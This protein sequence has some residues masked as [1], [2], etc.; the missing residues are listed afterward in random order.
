MTFTVDPPADGHVN[1]ARD[2]ELL[3]LAEGGQA[4]ARVYTWSEI[5]V[6]LGRF[7]T[8]EEALLQDVPSIVRPTG[9]RAVL[10]GHDM[11]VGI[12]I[13]HNLRGGAS[14]SVR[15]VYRTLVRPLALALRQ[16][17][18][19]AHLAEETKH[20]NKG[21]V[22][23]DCFAFSSPNDVVDDV[24][25]SKVCGCAL[26]VT[27]R[28]ALLQASI[29]YRESLLPIQ[30][31]IQGAVPIDLTPWRHDLLAESLRFALTL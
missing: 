20:A 9:G 28:A 5:W 1:M 4:G 26:R 11:T 10:H 30:E 2:V 14:R 31:V 17:G 16:C 8:A 25:G 12:A 27:D 18:L 6:T 19:T 22:S 23:A 21:L 13:P 24:T 3:R 15:E 7:Q 29:P